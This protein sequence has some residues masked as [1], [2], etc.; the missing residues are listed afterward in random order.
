ME[1]DLKRFSAIAEQMSVAIGRKLA[2]DALKTSEEKYRLVVEHANEA[3]IVIQDGLLR[4]INPMAMQLIGYD[5]EELLHQSFSQFIHPDDRAMVM[6]RHQKRLRGEPIPERYVFRTVRKDGEIRRIEI[7]ATVTT[8]QSQPATL[9]FLSDVTERELAAEREMQQRRNQTS[10]AETAVEFVRLGEHEDIYQHIC[11]RLHKLVGD[12]YVVV[13]SH[14]LKTDKFRVRSI[15]GLGNRLDAVLKLMG[16]KPEGTVFTLTPEQ[17]RE[18]ATDKLK[19]IEGGLAGLSFGQL[20]KPLTAALE[21]AFNVGEVYAMTLFHQGAILG[22]VNILL[23]R[24]TAPLDPEVVETFVNQAAVALQRRLAEDELRLHQHHLEELVEERTKELKQVQ[25][26]LV[27]QERLAAVGKVAG[28]MAHEIRNPLATMR[29]ASYFLTN[30]LGPK[31]EGKAA[32]HLEIIDQEIDVANSIITSV[33][34]FARGRPAELIP[35]NLSDVLEIALER[36]G[37]PPSVQVRRRIPSDLPMVRVDFQQMVQV[38]INLL[39]NAAQAMEGKGRITVSAEAGNGKVRVSFNNDGP[40]IKPEDLPR[41]FEPL[42]STKTVGIGMGLA[43]CKA[44]VEAGSGT[45]K[46]ESEPGKGA[47]FTVTLPAAEQGI[48]NSE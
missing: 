29:N 7:G 41:V 31:L 43:V 30:A 45:I 26:A 2:D 19:H 24:E 5:R 13:N 11:S 22:S 25:D 10:L 32:R 36:A 14:D 34:D 44:F 47:T 40:E 37:L 16:R 8:W 18:Y 27:R 4:F 28:S 12:A 6:D 3:I 21:R 1:S 23:R 46:A 20:P 38:F 42:F 48:V 39:V 17:Q 33:L 15:A 9:S 35:H